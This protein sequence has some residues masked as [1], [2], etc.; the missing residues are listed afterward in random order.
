MRV[1]P[2]IRQKKVNT[3]GVT[4][5]EI[6]QDVFG[7]P[8]ASFLQTHASNMSGNQGGGRASG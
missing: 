1:A 5:D 8:P 3:Y 2:K 6:R 7:M 4:M